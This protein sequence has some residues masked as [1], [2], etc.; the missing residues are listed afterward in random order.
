MASRVI[1][2]HR[3]LCNEADIVEYRDMLAII[4]DRIQDRVKKGMT[5]D[6]VKAA[7]P[8]RDQDTRYG[9]GDA[10]IEAA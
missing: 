3:R 8:I 1:P 6:Q 5:L 2:G 7:R 9:S 4:R 10:L